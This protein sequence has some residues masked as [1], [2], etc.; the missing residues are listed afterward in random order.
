MEAAVPLVLDCGSGM[1]K[2]GMGG[3]TLPRSVFPT[4]IG[5][6]KV[7]SGMPM[8]GGK[9][10]YIGDEAMSKKGILRLEYPLENG[11]IKNW[12]AMTS[13]LT[14]T[15]YNELRISI[16]EH[17]VLLTDSD[18]DP[19]VNKEKL[20]EILFEKMRVPSLFLVNPG[21]LSLYANAVITGT[22]IDCGDCVTLC[23]PGDGG[24]A[25]T[26]AIKKKYFGGRS[27]TN[28]LTQ[29][30][31]EQENL[32]TTTGEQYTVKTIKE[33]TC[34]IALDP[35]EASRSSP[36]SEFMLPDGHKIS[37]NKERWMC[38]EIL[39]TP[40]ASL[41]KE[42]EGL[43]QFVMGSILKCDEALRKDLLANV[44]LA[45]GSTMFPGLPER[46]DKELAKLVPAGLKA[47]VK[48]P[49]NRKYS[50]WIG[51]SIMTTLS[52]FKHMWLTKA[53]YQEGKGAI[54]ASKFPV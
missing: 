13:L 12:E 9:T 44:V 36:A 49:K 46:L 35:E 34:Y 39:F 18:R 29:L 52:T 2:A 32:F 16:E 26:K 21:I 11:M 4:L 24:M 1:T 43:A 47:E 8:M 38:P 28:Y 50:A 20:A 14:H 19:K 23:V 27:L 48:A 25:D 6:P 7:A 31:N 45:G 54:V 22:A 37:L 3:E 40:A 41:G 15:F 33:E 51:G 10:E 5:R 17:P 30:L 53:E 42:E